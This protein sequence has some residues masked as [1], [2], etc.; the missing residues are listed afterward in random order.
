MQALTVLWIVFVTNSFNLL[1][2]M[3]GLCAGTVSLT[4]GVL[5]L[6]ALAAG[7]PPLALALAA[8]CGASLGFL[9]YNLAP[10]TIFLGDAGSMFVGFLMACLTVATTYYQY[11]ESALS[12]GVP[13]MILAVPLYDTATV[14]WIRLREGRGLLT[15]DTSHFSHRLVDLGMS[16]RQAVATIHLAALAIALPAA[17]L[18]RLSDAEGIFL[19][20]QAVLILTLI[21][22]LERAGAQRAR[23]RREDGG[24]GGGDA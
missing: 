7:Q 10:A 17:V 3:D 12:V 2:N 24:E 1:D 19:I 14:F 8:L 6:V 18:R 15:G 11:R 20:A 5:A 22:L 13:L 16:R 9:R 21:A 23:G 4:S